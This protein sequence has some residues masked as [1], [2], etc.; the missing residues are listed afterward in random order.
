MQRLAGW[1]LENW[2]K[3]IFRNYSRLDR[4]EQRYNQISTLPNESCLIQSMPNT[5]QALDL[6]IPGA[7]QLGSVNFANQRVLPHFLTFHS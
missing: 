5:P 4:A 3:G 6:I 7:K 2:R 1:N